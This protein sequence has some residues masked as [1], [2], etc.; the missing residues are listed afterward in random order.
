MEVAVSAL[1][2]ELK[3][4]IERARAGDEIIITDRGVP[5][6]RLTGIAAADLVQGLVRDGLLTPAQLQRGAHEVPPELP[7]SVGAAGARAAVSGLV[8][9]IRR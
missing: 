4:W 3:S 6:A 8:R 1:R 5:V 7:S 2:A 9:R